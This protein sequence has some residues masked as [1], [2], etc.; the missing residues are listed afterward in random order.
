[1]VGYYGFLTSYCG[2]FFGG[3]GVQTKDG[4]RNYFKERLRNINKQDLS[5]IYFTTMEY[6][7]IEYSNSLIYLDPPYINTTKYKEEFDHEK[8]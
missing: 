3:Y 7:A 2:K 6:D 5:G 1:M 4:K 8:L